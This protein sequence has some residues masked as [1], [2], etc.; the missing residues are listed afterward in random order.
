MDGSLTFPGGRVVKV[1]IND[2]SISGLGFRCQEELSTTEEAVLVLPIS[3][4]MSHVQAQC[5]VVRLQKTTSPF[6]PWAGGLS[7]TDTNL[8]RRQTFIEF[9]ARIAVTEHA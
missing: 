3:F 2:L 5:R 6:F 1:Q 7:F 8:D 4:K 9:L